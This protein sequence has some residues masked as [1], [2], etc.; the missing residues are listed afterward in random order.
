MKFDR[1]LSGSPKGPESEQQLLNHAAYL[2]RETVN[3]NNGRS[4]GQL[5]IVEQWSADNGNFEIVFSEQALDYL[6]ELDDP[7][8]EIVKTLFN[9]IG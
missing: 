5:A 3:L 4:Q 2:A 1:I 7:R 6:H 9:Q 8:I